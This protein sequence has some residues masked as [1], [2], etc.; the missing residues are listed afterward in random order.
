MLTY[1]DKLTIIGNILKSDFDISQRDLS[2]EVL[3]TEAFYDNYSKD[4]SLQKE[5]NGV[6]RHEV[7][8]NTP[9]RVYSETELIPIS[10][11]QYQEEVYYDLLPNSLKAQP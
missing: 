3:K 11:Q 5:L 1:T 7:R 2:S 8:A 9:Y 10:I 6:I 4:T